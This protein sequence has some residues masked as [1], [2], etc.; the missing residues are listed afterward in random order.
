MHYTHDMS[1]EPAMLVVAILSFVFGGL[2]GYLG[3]RVAKKIWPEKP[4][5]LL[6]EELGGGRHFTGFPHA[7]IRL[8]IRNPN[9]HA[10]SVSDVTL[11]W[12]REEKL[13]WLPPYKGSL[14]DEKKIGPFV[15]EIVDPPFRIEAG[16]TREPTL[17]FLMPLDPPEYV[18]SL[19]EGMS[20]TLLLRDSF[21]EIYNVSTDCLR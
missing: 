11:F 3:Q 17:V 9:T 2:I 6:I 5:R 14:V 4:R 7:Y 1:L 20:A 12:N 13:M 18:E 21:N 10:V 8:R 16:D 19:R 15:K